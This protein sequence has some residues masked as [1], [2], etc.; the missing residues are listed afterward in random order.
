MPRYHATHAGHREI[1]LVLVRQHQVAVAKNDFI[2]PVD[3][4]VFQ[5]DAF[6]LSDMLLVVGAEERVFCNRRNHII[7]TLYILKL[8]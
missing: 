1:V 2:E 4:F 5:P 3:L 6:H 7:N 8:T